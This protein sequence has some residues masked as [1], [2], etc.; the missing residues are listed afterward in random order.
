MNRPSRAA[1][2]NSDTPAAAASG[3]ISGGLLV[4]ITKRKA[5][6][7]ARREKA[8]KCG[9][10]RVALESEIAAG[11][12]FR[13]DHLIGEELAGDDSAETASDSRDLDGGE[14]TVR[15][16]LRGVG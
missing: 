4:A 6:E 3:S 15:V 16:K 10:G 13:L 8:L 14:R 7:L 2:S 9:G 12:A 1:E 5:A 11:G